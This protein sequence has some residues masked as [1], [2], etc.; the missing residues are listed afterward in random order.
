MLKSRVKFC[1]YADPETAQ[2][3][4]F[5]TIQNTRYVQEFTNK[6]SGS[7]VFTIPPNNGIQDIILTFEIPANGVGGVDYRAAGLNRGWGYALN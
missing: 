3:Q 5:R 4:C 6:S 2:K 1:Y 7:S